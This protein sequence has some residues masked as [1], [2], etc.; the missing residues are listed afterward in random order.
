MK[1]KILTLGLVAA[2]SA[3]AAI[4][5]TLAYFTDTATPV[6]NVFTVGNVKIKIEEDNWVE[7]NAKD[8]YPGQTL[9]KD[10]KVKNTGKNICFIRAK[11]VNLDQFGTGKEITVDE[12][13]AGWEYNAADGYYYWTAAVDKD[14]VT[15]C[16]FN[17]ITMPTSLD[18]KEG[19][20]KPITIEAQAVQA[21]GFSGT[22][23]DAATLQ[24][25][26]ETCFG[27]GNN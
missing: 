25:W 7:A 3:T 13:G 19:D 1:K 8:V 21:Q 26:F 10:P 6:N 5:G 23:M 12:I 17:S 18:G 14:S 4:G 20:A 16:L 27:T 9:A 24:T 15:G 22:T 11:I 2:L